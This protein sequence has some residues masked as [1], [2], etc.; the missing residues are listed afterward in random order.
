MARVRPEN[1]PSS[2]REKV[3][4]AATASSTAGSAAMRVK[5]AT[6]R[7]CSRAPGTLSF[8]AR[9]NPSACHTMVLSIARMRT[10]FIVS[11]VQTYSLRGAIAVSPVR[12]R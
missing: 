3:V 6:M 1:Q 8:H 4:V 10:A 2:E 12:M 7:V 5:R 11:A 9:R